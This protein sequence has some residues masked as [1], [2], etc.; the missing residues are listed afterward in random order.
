MWEEW[1][2]YFSPP[3]KKAQS[4]R[5]DF[6][7]LISENVISYTE[8]VL[9]EYGA[10]DDGHE[11]LVYW[12][13]KRDGNSISI[14]SVIA[15]ETISSEGRVTVPPL[16]NFYVIQ[17]ISKAKLVQLG[18][19]HS[20][21]GK[22]VGHSYGDD[23][24]ASF[25]RDGLLSIVVPSYCFGGMLPLKEC[26]IHRYEGHFVRLSKKYIQKHFTITTEKGELFDLRKRNY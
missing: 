4:P 9:K 6:R 25:K 5:D 8:A 3:E 24:N 2:K 11:G 14:N 12:A 20:H 18:Q 19:V 17:C 1:L 21:P 15:P 23:A 10:I 22:W 26:G 7:Y 16:S 13:G